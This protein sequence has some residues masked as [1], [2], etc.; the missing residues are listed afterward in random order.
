MIGNP[1]FEESADVPATAGASGGKYDISIGFE[2]ENNAGWQGH[3]GD[4]IFTPVFTDPTVD[5][6]DARTGSFSLVWT[7]DDLT[8]KTQIY[9]AISKKIKVACGERYQ[10][11]V[12]VKT[13]TT[14]R[15][16]IFGASNV[17]TTH[18]TNGFIGNG[19]G[20]AELDNDPEGTGSTDGTW[21][22]I[23]LDVTFVIC[24][25]YLAPTLYVVYLDTAAGPITRIDDWSGAGYNLGMYSWEPTNFS[26]VTLFDRD[27]TPPTPARDGAATANVTTTAANHGIG[28]PIAVE[29]GKTYTF[30]AYIHHDIGSD[31]T[32]TI[33]IV[34]TAGGSTIATTNTVVSTGGTW[35]QLEVTGVVDV[36]EVHI[37]ILKV[38]SG[39]F[40]I[41]D[42]DLLEGFAAQTVG[43]IVGAI[44]DDAASDHASQNRTA[45]AWLNENYSDT[46]DADLVNWNQD[47]SLRLKR[48][49]TY[50]QILEQITG[51]GYEFD[52]RPDPADDTMIELSAYNSGG[53]GS[54][55]A[56]GNGKA[57]I[58][59]F[60]ALG[61][62]I[63]RE[64]TATYVMA[65]GDALEWA[66]VR[67]L[68]LEV[69]W[70]EIESYIGSKDNLVV[71]LGLQANTELARVGLEDL[72]AT[73]QGSTMTPGIDYNIGDTV[74]VT[75]GLIPSAKYRTVGITVAGGP[76]SPEPMWQVSFEAETVIGPASWTH[77]E[78]TDVTTVPSGGINGDLLVIMASINLATEWGDLTGWT[79]DF[80][81]QTSAGDPRAIVHYSRIWNDEPANYTLPRSADHSVMVVLKGVSGFAAAAATDH[82]S[83]AADFDSPSVSSAAGEIVFRWAYT[84]G[85]HDFQPLV[86]FPGTKLVN[87]GPDASDTGSEEIVYHEADAGSTGTFT[88][89]FLGAGAPEF[90]AITAVY[91]LK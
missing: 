35:T 29:S 26:I 58:N 81:I 80:T 49:S 22:K 66:D 84:E 6:G 90:Y 73:F 87:P 82:Q 85:S 65:E 76:G 17:V 88:W 31:Q 19:I 1:S 78:D 39:T 46:Q 51:F 79:K 61:P 60:V 36:D 8:G 23:D 56:L 3:P 12:Y 41:D 72:R 42:S 55:L 28:Y 16:F 33:R 69:P 53:L 83:V 20:W 18:H 24:A 37:Q 57:I 54:N 75:P 74:R 50:R 7:P 67:D 25:N 89:E 59:G 70:G 63:R 5:N 30:I 68:G 91:N 4:D 48:G 14:G 64:P 32:F 2:D 10:F 13:P 21:Q 38:T 15:R 62:L 45:L 40:W 11:T 44:Y 9:S 43:E 52:M 27:I 34:R 47:I 77:V 86:P 71:D